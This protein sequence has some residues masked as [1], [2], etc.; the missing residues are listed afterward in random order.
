[1]AYAEE[2]G[3]FAQ[4]KE[5]DACM[6]VRGPLTQ[7]AVAG[8]D[9]IFFVRCDFAAEHH[10]SRTRNRCLYGHLSCTVLPERRVSRMPRLCLSCDFCNVRVC[11]C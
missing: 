6:E 9:G 11:C 8:D 2:G 10:V 4:L 5:V 3:D 7:L 1:M